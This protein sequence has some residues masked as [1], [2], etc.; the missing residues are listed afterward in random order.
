MTAVPSC[1]IMAQLAAEQLYLGKPIMHNVSVF[2]VF[3]GWFP[4]PHSG[5][6]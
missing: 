6:R 4:Y 1:R 2:E 5:L 3:H